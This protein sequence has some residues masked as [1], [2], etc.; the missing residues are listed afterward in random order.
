V[1]R[2]EQV[3]LTC[4]AMDQGGPITAPYPRTIPAGFIGRIPP[5]KY[6]FFFK[7]RVPAK[8]GFKNPKG[9][10]TLYVANGCAGGCGKI[11]VITDS[12]DRDI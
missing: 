9:I 7:I 2:A 11:A 6:S 12:V 10:T 8:A 1:A 4:L 3:R 5:S